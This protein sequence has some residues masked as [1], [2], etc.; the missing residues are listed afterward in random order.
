M[1]VPF[2][3]EEDT[4]PLSCFLERCPA[5]AAGGAFRKRGDPF[6]FLP[7]LSWAHVALF[8]DLLWSPIAGPSHSSSVGHPSLPIPGTT[9]VPSPIYP[10]F[11]EFLSP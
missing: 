5:T 6:H 1:H 2:A 3:A 9:F 8:L 10:L 7:S 11:S 4:E